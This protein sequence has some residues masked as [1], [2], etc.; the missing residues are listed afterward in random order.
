MKRPL[1]TVALVYAGGVVTGDLLPA[2]VAWLLALSLA[3]AAASLLLPKA[4]LCLL[5]L[6]LFLVG[7]TNLAGRTEI[8]SP[9]DLRRLMGPD[10]AI[11]SVRGILI[12]TP[13]ER[14]LKHGSK[15]IRRT[16]AKL[17]I[18]AFKTNAIW[19]PAFGQ[20]A[21]TTRGL[22]PAG[23]FTG[24]TVEIDGV[25]HPPKPPVVPELF[26]YR[27]YLRRLGI[28]YQ[29]DVESANDWRRIASGLGE[30][31][32]PLADRFRVWAQ[33]TLEHGLPEEDESL[34][35]SWAM[36]LGW[37]TALTGEVSEPFMRT[38]TMHIFAIS[39]LH[40]ALI[41]GILVALLRVLRVSRGICGWFVI[42]LIWFYTMATGWQSSAIRSTIMMTVIIAG[43]SLKR[44]SDLLNSLAASGFI[45]LLWDP[46][47][48]FQASFQL[49]FLVV[50]SMALLLPPIEAVR[51]RLVRTDPLL[52]PE[53]LPSWRR[54][55]DGP[56]HFLTTG[57]AT[58]LAAWFGSL[59]LIAFYFHLFTP[60]SLLA[61][62]VIVP[63]SSLALMCNLGSLLGAWWPWLNELFNYSGWFWMEAMIRISDWFA[64]L[65]AAY[66]YVKAPTG[67]EFAGYYAILFGALTGWLLA[68]SR[69]IWAATGLCALAL[70]GAARWAGH[71][72]DS[73]VTVLPL[74]GGDAI[75]IDAPGSKNDMLVDCGN[76]SA[77]E[78][79]VKPFL[80]G[81]GMN[82][83]TH[84]LLTHG[85]LR[86]IGGAP[87]VWKEYPAAHILTSSVP[88]RSPKYRQIMDSLEESPGCRREINLGDRLGDWT[89]LHPAQDD[90]Y[91]EA[92][93]NA[94][95]LRGRIHGIRVLL[96]SDLGRPGQAALLERQPDL[97]ADVV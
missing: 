93:D 1:L 16:I 29:L 32:P 6:L 35:L 30:D 72:H 8:L 13:S 85:D 27:A 48:L 97:R 70:L 55:L 44:P 63:L 40:I 75:F 7:W 82:R 5:W 80:R 64:A 79:I 91:V 95:V 71:R 11:V 18:S 78:F 15:E 34:R 68:P 22:L 24:Q 58:S 36:A 86:H 62:L 87:L 46:Q 2:S 88:F 84:L 59:P 39:G 50:L 69:R 25:I 43:W 81:Q 45:I 60:V 94:L 89:V 61:N 19:C 37:T 28:H 38:G 23:F 74:S 26:D 52:P 47:Q 83:L 42:P 66:V 12:E 51:R 77:V 96:C 10:A 9:Y 57:F 33:R 54:W 14:V 90:R 20:I 56:I 31:R 73:C 17:E 67:V 65:P 49:S 4:R 3:V 76:E 53:L 21:V 92:D 41:A